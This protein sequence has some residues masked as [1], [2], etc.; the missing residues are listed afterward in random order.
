MRKTWSQIVLQPGAMIGYLNGKI[1]A[2][3]NFFKSSGISF[4]ELSNL[5][6]IGAIVNIHFL[7]N[8]SIS[9]D[10]EYAALRSDPGVWVG[11][12]RWTTYLVERLFVPQPSVPFAPY[13]LLIVSLAL[14]YSLLIRI[15][16]FKVNWKTYLCYP[17]FAGFPTW[18]FISEFYANTPAVALGVLLTCGS[19]FLTYF[20]DAEDSIYSSAHIKSG[21]FA[22]CLLAT[23]IGAYQSTLLL[24]LTITLG[25]LMVRCIRSEQSAKAIWPLLIKRYVQIFLI[26]FASAVLYAIIDFLAKRI[27][28]IQSSDYINGFVRLENFQHPVRLLAG[29]CFRAWKV[30]SGSATLY[31]IG[32]VKIAGVVLI[33]ATILIAAASKKKILLNV[34]QWAIVLLM[35]FGL[36]FMSGA[37]SMPFRSMLAISYV[38]WLMVILLVSYRNRIFATLGVLVTLV[39]QL[40]IMTLLSQYMAAATITQAHDRLLAA[41]L[42]RRIG[43]Q[44]P[45]FDREK[46]IEIDVYGKKDVK[47]IYSDSWGSATQGSFFDWDNGNIHRMLAYMTVLGYTN[48]TTLPEEGRRA[49]TALF[50]DMPVWPAQGSVK[51]V[52]KLYLIKLSKNPDPVHKELN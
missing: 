18:W 13:I 37:D 43:E 11:Q 29:I 25:T 10:D 7:A 27:M 30:Y 8:F 44:S 12:G 39:F 48:V 14:S 15:H 2:L 52:G 5:T 24:Y 38:S 4:R 3:L 36:H 32:G 22:A 40:Q 34:V 47:L 21:F 42:Y 17:I 9:I 16:G 1:E 31:G 6:L 28:H 45:D 19:A 20:K 41:D 49:N 35:P 51:L 23:A 50:K 46:M 33:L 26:L